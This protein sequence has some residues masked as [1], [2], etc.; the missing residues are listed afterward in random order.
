MS[1]RKWMNQ[2]LLLAGSLVTLNTL[3]MQFTLKPWVLKDLSN[4]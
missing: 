2:T 1:R 3:V 4:R